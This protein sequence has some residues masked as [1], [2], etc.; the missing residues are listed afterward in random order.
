MWTSHAGQEIPLG[1]CGCAFCDRLAEDAL[2]FELYPISVTP[3]GSQ[4]YLSGSAPVCTRCKTLFRCSDGLVNWALI[5]G[6]AISAVAFALAFTTEL[7]SGLH[8]YVQLGLTFGSVIVGGLL[9]LLLRGWM[10]VRFFGCL[11][12]GYSTSTDVGAG[13]QIMEFLQPPNFDRRL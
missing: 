7:L 12:R 11:R 3:W 6:I 5:L 1:G 8:I 4:E 9:T 2:H 13:V 10:S